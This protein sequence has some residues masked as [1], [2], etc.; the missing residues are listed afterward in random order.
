MVINRV[1]W[2]L[3][4]LFDLAILPCWTHYTMFVLCHIHKRLKK[5]MPLKSSRCTLSLS[6]QLNWTILSYKRHPRPLLGDA[7]RGRTGV[8]GP[9]TGKHRRK[10][11]QDRGPNSR[12]LG[13][14]PHAR[15]PH[16]FSKNVAQNSLN[17]P[18]ET[19]KIIF[20]GKVPS[21]SPDPF[22]GGAHSSPTDP[23]L[24]SPQNSGQIYTCAGMVNW[25][26]IFGPTGASK[27]GLWVRIVEGL[28]ELSV[29][30]PELALNGSAVAFYSSP[31]IRH[32]FPN[33]FHLGS[34][35]DGIDNCSRNVFPIQFCQLLNMLI[36]RQT[37]LY[38]THARC[39]ERP[40][41]WSTGARSIGALQKKN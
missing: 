11:R 33:R 41:N 40:T 19:K 39:T 6:C 7:E 8:S 21:P 14:V 29:T 20:P 10:W 34:W 24:V 4:R 26:L 18:F 17:Q 38:M 37:F 5:A 1:D 27:T 12:E 2:P 32:Q 15:C 9:A 30:G 28:E 22:L 23:P 35:T 3:S 16:R 13:L 36:P 31:T 25:A